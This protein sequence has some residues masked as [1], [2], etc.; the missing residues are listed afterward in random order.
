[1]PIHAM[2]R[3]RSSRRTQAERSEM[4]HGQA[5]T[6]IYRN[7]IATD[8]FTATFEFRLGDGDGMGLMLQTKGETAVG[9][10]G[11]GLCMAELDGYGVELDTYFPSPRCL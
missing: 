8:A 10:P 5:G 11:G 6:I 2:D 7:P 4:R 3:G 9:E 1:M